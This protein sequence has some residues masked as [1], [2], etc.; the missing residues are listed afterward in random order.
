MRALFALLFACFLSAPVAAQETSRPVP[1]YVESMPALFCLSQQACLQI[2]ESFSRSGTA[3]AVATFQK[4]DWQ[5]MTDPS[6]PLS[7]FERRRIAE[8][9]YGSHY[10]VM[11]AVV[12]RP[13]E[14]PPL[15]G[16]LLVPEGTI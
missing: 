1:R 13:P 11:Y 9:N 8:W 5:V 14:G 12:L 4:V 10:L 6:V 3:S 2:G 7:F 15:G 16:Y